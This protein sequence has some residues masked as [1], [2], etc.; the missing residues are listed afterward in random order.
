MSIAFL[1]GNRTRF[2]SLLAKELTKGRS[3]VQDVEQ[4]A[5][6]HMRDVNNCIK[7]L[8]VFIKKL[9]KANEKLSVAMEGRDGA[10]EI[11]ELIKEDPEFTSSV[12]DCRV[13]LM[14]IN[15]PEQRSPTDNY[16]SATITEDTF[17]QMIQMACQMQ[18]VIIGQQQL[19]QQQ[20][21]CLSVFRY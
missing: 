14:D 21:I 1:K 15:I 4:E 3:L 8:N 20:Q 11:E 13:E 9:E 7:K 19:Q 17:D 12:M 18:Q 5:S 16:S 10:E 2:R 6:I